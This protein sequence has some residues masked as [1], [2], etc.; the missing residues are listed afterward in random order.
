MAD[1]HFYSCGKVPA[2]IPTRWSLRFD[3][4]GLSP[5]FSTVLLVGIIVVAGTI[6]YYFSV[7]LTTSATN[8]YVGAMSN[9]QQSI[10]E[11]LSFEAVSYVNPT[12]NSPGTLT[13]YVVNSG[14]A[15]N[16]QLDNLFLYNANHNLVSVYSGNSILPLRSISSGSPISGNALNIGKE[17]YFIVSLGVDNSG[18]YI[19]LSPGAMYTLHLIT[20]SGS[21]FDHDISF[22]Q[23][24]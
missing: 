13:I 19:S 16:L 5:I 8:Q 7:N 1:K 2:L 23:T 9:S 20:K 4:R 22:G 10:S 12:A 14:K 3:R 6:A 17:G 24:G 18:K 11:R 21:T 15:N